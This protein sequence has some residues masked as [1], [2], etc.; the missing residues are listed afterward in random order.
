MT[1]ERVSNSLSFYEFYEGIG[2]HRAHRQILIVPRL[3]GDRFER[4]R[5]VKT[6]KILTIL[7][8]ALTLMVCAA[9]PG[10]DSGQVN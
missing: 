10:F 4:R 9:Q 7:V 8:L 1:G 6:A 5:K 3:R 2:A